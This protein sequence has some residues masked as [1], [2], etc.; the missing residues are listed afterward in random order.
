MICCDG[1]TDVMSG[2]EIVEWVSNELEGDN[3]EEISAR[4]AETAIQKGSTDNVSVIIV[5]LH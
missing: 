5:L 4:L 3:F 1:L 2:D